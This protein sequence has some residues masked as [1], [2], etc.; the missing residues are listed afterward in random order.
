MRPVVDY[1]EL[2]KKIVLQSI[3][4]PDLHSCF[5]WFH[6]ATVFTTFDL[7]QAYFQLP[8]AEE[9][10]PVTAFVTDW[11]LYEYN[12][13][14]FGL[15]TGAA[16]LSRIL[17]NVFS[18]LKFNCLYHYLDDLVIFSQN[19]QEHVEHVREVLKRLREAG[20]TVKPSKVKF[21]K[22][23]ISFLGHIVS[24]AGVSIDQTRTEA[25][26]KFPVP[27]NVKGVARLVGMGNFFRKFVPNFAQL[28]APLNELRKKGKRF[29]WGPSQQAAFEGLKNAL[30]S[31]P[32]L[33]IPDFEKQFIVQTDASAS[34]V[35]AVLLQECPGG[36]R[37]VAYAS[38]SLSPLEVKY[39]VYE[40]EALAVLFA[41]EKFKMYLEHKPFQL[42]TDNQA[43][44]WV[45]A[46]PRRTGRIARWAVRISAFQFKVKHIRGTENVVADGLSR[47]FDDEK[48]ADAHELMKVI[49]VE[50]DEVVCPILTGLPQFFKD[51][52]Q[53]QDKDSE[54]AT[55]K[56]RLRGGENVKP[57]TIKGNILC[58]AARGR[59][60]DKIV[61]PGELVPCIFKYFHETPLGGHLGNF[62][63]RMKIRERF[64]WKGMDKQIQ[65]LV[66]ECKVCGISKPNVNSRQGLLSSDIELSPMS[67]MYIDYVGPFPRSKEGNRFALVCVDA[68]TR[69]CWLLPT[70]NINALTTIKC[71]QSIFGTFGPCRTIVSDNATAF[72]SVAFRDFCF[73]MG[74]V[75]TTT[76]PY[77]PNPS[78]AERV[79]RN[80]RSALIA[81]HHDNHSKW[82]TS[83]CW[84]SYAFNTAIHEAH[85]EAPVNLMFAFKPNSP[86][87]NLWALDDLLPEKIDAAQIRNTWKRAKRNLRSSHEKLAQRYNVGRRPTALKPG[88]QVFVRNFGAV[89]KGADKVM[90]KLLPRFK[91]PVEIVRFITPVTLLVRDPNKR[92]IC[93]VH[94]SHVK[95]YQ[96]RINS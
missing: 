26:H 65:K 62:K 42:E 17:D 84:L 79:N 45:L 31:A 74:I 54:L 46:R 33:A 9:S 61:L 15:S 28:V 80:L 55:I 22:P 3:P 16:V 12:R 41:L 5:A 70:R 11:N 10:K 91:G 86:L 78:F 49:E 39:S 68:C 19:F 93:R 27:K 58:C 76:T 64:I 92:R 71:L 4:L 50:P 21:A 44:S 57:Y 96:S 47:M 59:Q 48:H 29:E 36:R 7:N 53:H 89:S 43:L 81:F 8:L 66:R 77:Y 95:P 67:K 51:I 56:E 52:G 87:S 94:L 34:G 90:G 63:T 37:P 24:R 14:P 88:D 72:T 73:E 6:K 23:E 1:R 35:A 32:V 40:L 75:H 20:F 25:I 13:V 38:R 60:G 82:D 85:K 69:F 83:L 2:N 18:D 30:A